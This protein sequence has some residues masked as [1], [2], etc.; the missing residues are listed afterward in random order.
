MIFAWVTPP[1][2][3][4]QHWCEAACAAIGQARP[5]T[6]QA[7]PRFMPSTAVFCHRE[8]GRQFRPRTED[9]ALNCR[10][11]RPFRGVGRLIKLLL[12]LRVHASKT[13]S[14][15]PSPFNIINSA[16]NGPIGGWARG[17]CQQ[18]A[19]HISKF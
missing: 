19:C 17:N 16:S 7:S 2:T 15:F 18:V 13:R 8:Y 10:Y 11:E 9:R 14:N 3:S 4:L 6:K 12:K 5:V 1:T